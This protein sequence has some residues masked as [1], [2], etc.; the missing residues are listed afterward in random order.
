MNDGR[1]RRQA[2][3]ARRHAR[4]RAVRPVTEASRVE[5]VLEALN[6]QHPLD[7]LLLVG[8]MIEVLLPHQFSYRAVEVDEGSESRVGGSPRDRSRRGRRSADHGGV[9][10][11]VGRCA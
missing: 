10:A 4:R 3:Q 6:G 11:S 5:V 2:K 8:R 9:L 7:M 1:K